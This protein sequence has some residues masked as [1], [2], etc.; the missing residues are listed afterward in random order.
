MTAVGR[1]IERRNER[2]LEEVSGLKHL[3]VM[4]S[5]EQGDE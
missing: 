3:V 1:I 5:S 2:L 4:D